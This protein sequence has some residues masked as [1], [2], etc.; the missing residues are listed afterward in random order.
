MLEDMTKKNTYELIGEGIETI[1]SGKKIKDIL[2][3]T[4]KSG[5]V[6]DEEIFI[7]DK[8]KKK[9]P[10]SIF[11]QIRKNK[12]GS[13]IGCFFGLIDL[14]EIKKKEEALKESGQVLEIKVAAE[15]RELQN[16]TNT[17]ETNIKK[18][19]K[20]LEEKLSELERINKLM[21]GRELKMIELKEKI[22]KAGKEIA[23]LK[24]NSI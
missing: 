21:V 9:I 20:E 5:I 22:K 4:L 23:R 12:K 11:S 24:N 8:E 14:T 10:V 15:T 3:E 1:F 2:E 17:L 16:L 19:T 7:L 18:R 6:R 13:N